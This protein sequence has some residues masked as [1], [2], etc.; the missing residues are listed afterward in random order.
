MFKSPVLSGG[1]LW[2]R[3]WR[4]SPPQKLRQRRRLRRVDNVIATLDSALRRGVALHAGNA[5]SDTVKSDAAK[6]DLS[7]YRHGRGPRLGDLAPGTPHPKL[8]IMGENSAFDVA[9]TAE[10]KTRAQ[11]LETMSAR[12]EGRSALAERGRAMNSAASIGPTLTANPT[13]PGTQTA[14]P[15]GPIVRAENSAITMGSYARARGTFK[16][17]E[18]W[19]AEMPTEREMLPKDKYTMFDRKRRSYRKGVHLLPK[20]TRVSQRVNPPGF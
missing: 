6:G 16:L 2:K 10:G 18:R 1:L 15:N 4:T 5:K 7:A 17:L 3:P 13:D 11:V 8:G 19:K 14:T 9:G 20:W 12:G